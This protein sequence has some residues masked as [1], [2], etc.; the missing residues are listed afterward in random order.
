VKQKKR[1]GFTL[2]ELLC[3]L[4]IL[5]LV[6]TAAVTG[7]TALANAYTRML[8]K[9]QAEELSST[10]T[11]A[12]THE[13]SYAKYVTVTGS[14]DADGY[15]PVSGFYSDTYRKCG[16]VLLTGTDNT[17]SAAWTDTA[18][19]GR[20]AIQTAAGYTPLPGQ[21]NYPIVADDAYAPNL[22]AQITDLSY[23]ADSGLF[24][25]TLRISSARADGICTSTFSVQS[26]NAGMG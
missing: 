12:V 14:G 9:S 11:A 10:L 13:L 1:R 3:T 18:Q 19:K 8:E 16:Y 23:N 20:I 25:V 21:N 17:A 22:S 24:R 5:S 2:T 6:M 4:L 26:L 7:M 15:A